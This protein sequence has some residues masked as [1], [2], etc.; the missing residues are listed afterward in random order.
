MSLHK[1]FDDDI[2]RLVLH[3]NRAART[4]RRRGK[5]SLEKTA[6]KLKIKLTSTKLTLK[7]PLSYYQVL[8]YNP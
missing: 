5:T 2:G 3:T 7:L 1:L 4:G 8:H 6:R